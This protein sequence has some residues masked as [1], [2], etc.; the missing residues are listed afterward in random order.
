M[1]YWPYEKAGT[2]VIPLQT[3][4]DSTAGNK[5]QTVEYF[6]WMNIMNIIN[7]YYFLLTIAPTLNL[8]ILINL[9]FTI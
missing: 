8:D 2:D 5:S 1:A 9:Y 4:Q 7:V 3:A 6:K